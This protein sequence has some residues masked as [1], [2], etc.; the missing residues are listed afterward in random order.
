MNK[1]FLT[2]TLL[3]ATVVPSLLPKDAS[4]GSSACTV[5]TWV[6]AEDLAPDH[7]SHGELRIKVLQPHCADSIASVA[8]RLELNEFGKVKHLCWEAVIPEIKETDNQTLWGDPR[9]LYDYGPYDKAMH[10]PTLWFVKAE[11]R[12][13]WSTVVR[14]FENNPNFSQPLVKPFIVASPAVNYPPSFVNYRQING[15]DLVKRHAYNDLRYH[16]TAVVNFTDGRTVDLKAGYTTFRPTST[17]PLASKPSSWNTTFSMYY[18]TCMADL[19]QAKE[20]LAQR[21]KCLPESLRSAFIAEV[22]LEDGQT[23][24]GQSDPCYERIHAD[25]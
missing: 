8:L 13:V 5:Q 15:F 9:T 22:T 1:I 18:E 25:V 17:R 19:P 2:V 20:M 11:E 3:A 10:D 23:I 6:R 21:E 7:V 4:T 24:E 12:T 14:L 16:Y